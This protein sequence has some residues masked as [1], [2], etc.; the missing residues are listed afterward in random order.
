MPLHFKLCVSEEIGFMHKLRKRLFKNDV[1]AKSE[2]LTPLLP[3]NCYSFVIF[4]W[5]LFKNLRPPL[6]QNVDALYE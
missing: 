4:N 2:F 3:G 5:R 6:A 1:L